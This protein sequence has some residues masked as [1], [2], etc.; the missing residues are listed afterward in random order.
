M[1]NR[2]YA[3]F[4]APLGS[5]YEK[6]QIY[7]T[8]KKNYLE[9]ISRS[10]E[11]ETEEPT[12][13]SLLLT[14]EL[15]VRLSTTVSTSIQAA[16]KNHEPINMRELL[17]EDAIGNFDQIIIDHDNDGSIIVTKKRKVKFQCF[18]FDCLAYQLYLP[19]N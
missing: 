14:T 6:A 15:A 18:S 9:Q 12:E 1:T 5:E 13:S 19:V 16:S 2:F 11:D 3:I 4:I 7:Y 8:I 10:N 17:G